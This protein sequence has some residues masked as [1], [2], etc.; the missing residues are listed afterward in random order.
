MTDDAVLI[1]SRPATPSAS[2][3]PLPPVGRSSLLVRGL[4]DRDTPLMPAAVGLRAPVLA[5]LDR[6]L[7]QPAPSLLPQLPAELDRLTI[8]P[9]FPEKR[10]RQSWT[11]L[12]ARLRFVEKP[13]GEPAQRLVAH[14]AM[15]RKPDKKAVTGAY[16]PIESWSLLGSLAWDDLAFRQTVAS[17]ILAWLREGYLM[18]P[19]ALPVLAPETCWILLAAAAGDGRL[20]WWMRGARRRSAVRMEVTRHLASLMALRTPGWAGFW[21]QWVLLRLLD[22]D[23]GL[24]GRLWP[25]LAASLS[26]LPLA[27]GADC[28]N[29]L[30][31]AD[32]LAEQ[33][34]W[35][36]VPS[37][38]SL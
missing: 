13:D 29:P 27:G 20:R 5:V 1:D 4:P 12:I 6:V 35:L 22:A 11:Q 34:D 16:M 3:E 14:A 8:P 30:V 26:P 37:R 15:Q 10:L 33:P 36:P 9:S 2:P 38:N 23:P 18:R 19:G 28:A 24:P 31:R 32:W 17:R 21:D 25:E 7:G